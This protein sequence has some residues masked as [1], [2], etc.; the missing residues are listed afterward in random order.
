M[1][2]FLLAFLTGLT[3]GGISCIAVQGG[4]LAATIADSGKNKIKTTLLFLIA[5]LVAYTLLGGFLGLF[6]ASFVVA[7]KVQGWLQIAV[8]LFMVATAAR[9]LNIHPIFRYTVLQPPVKF[10]RILSKVSKDTSNFAPIL[11]G[12]LTVLIPCG[13]TQAMMIYA[14]GSGSVLNGA[15]TMFA[16]VLGTFPIFFLFGV[17]STEVFKNKILT[18]VAATIILYIG[19]LSINSGQILRGSVHTLQNYWSVIAGSNIVSGKIN[20]E[21]GYQLV[22]I[23]VFAKGYKADTNTLKV[24]VPVKLTLVSNNVLSCARAFVIP[25]LGISKI[26]PVTGE[27]VIEFTPTTTGILTYTCSMGMYTGYFNV[28]K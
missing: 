16:F 18:A 3:S 8:G 10:M 20:I 24:G 25:N 14:I 19:V 17:V 22:K 23:D 13:V 15:L 4:L 6:G 9:L 7:P 12:F 28:V 26:L 2:T 21:N 11:L 1:N 5:K 27:T